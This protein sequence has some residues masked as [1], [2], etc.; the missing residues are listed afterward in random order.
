VAGDALALL[1]PLLSDTRQLPA[2]V[3]AAALSVLLL[4]TAGRYR[5]RLHPSVLDELPAILSRLVAAI[6]L[7]ATIVA[8]RGGPE[9]VA[10]FLSNCASAV[11]LLVAGR[12]ATTRLIAWTRERG[13]GVRR[14]LMIG[15][16]TLAAELADVLDNHPGYGLAVVGY[17]DDD[18]GRPA[19]DLLPRLGRLSDVESVVR[20]GRVDVLIVTP[21]AGDECALPGLLRNPGCVACDIFAVPRLYHLH[22]RPAP[23]DRIGSVPVVRVLPPNLSRSW[24]A[25]RRAADATVSALVLAVLVPVVATRVAASKLG[26]GQRRASWEPVAR[27][28]TVLRGGLSLV[29]PYPD[30]PDHIAEVSA[31]YECSRLRRRAQ[32]GLTGPAQISGRHGHV[33]AHE[34]A[35]YDNYYIENWSLWL[36]L[37]IVMTALSHIIAGRR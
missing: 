26:N 24:R 10:T 28:W 1:T 2:T 27:L 37:K 14:T 32:A 13:Y 6:A 5:A 19:S 31:R 21:E 3:A 22:V 9:A 17:V 36:D 16:G 8:L 15:G 11:V 12:A 35:R 34:R 30:R 29:G 33:S 23:T 7:V 25:V 20:N 18:D 4:A